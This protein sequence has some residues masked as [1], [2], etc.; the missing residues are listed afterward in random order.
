MNH[1]LFSFA[2][3]QFARLDSEENILDSLRR[4]FIQFRSTV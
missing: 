3:V 4:F 1:E 2:C